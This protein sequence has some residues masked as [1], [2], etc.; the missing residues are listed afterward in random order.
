MDQRAFPQSA[1]EGNLVS[2]Y[3]QSKFVFEDSLP[4]SPTSSLD[5]CSDPY[6][7]AAF[8]ATPSVFQTPYS[9]TSHQLGIPSPPLTAKREERQKRK[10]CSNKNS[11]A[12]K[13]LRRNSSRDSNA[14]TA[15]REGGTGRSNRSCGTHGHHGSEHS[16][17]Q[18]KNHSQHTK[19][20]NR[21]ASGKF[22]AKKREHMLR[23]QSEEQELERT[24]YDLSICVA[25]LTRE[26]QELKMKLLQHTDC[27]C[28]LIHD[29]LAVEAQRYVC[30]LS[31]QSQ[32]KTTSPGAACN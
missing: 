15:T 18:D 7:A 19:E 14:N 10:R 17:Q 13:S 22:R 29:F 4:T 2:A 32:L 25:N 20:R 16:G 8:T 28:S 5:H 3:R 11:S 27:D 24:N 23:V 31:M 21:I 30:G 12:R 26:V 6:P 9:Q 1:E